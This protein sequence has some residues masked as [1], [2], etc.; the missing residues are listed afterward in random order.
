MDK[1]TTEETPSSFPKEVIVKKSRKKR[2][3]SGKGSSQDGG[4][5]GIKSA[6]IPAKVQKKLKKEAVKRMLRD[7]LKKEMKPL[8]LGSI[9]MLCST[10]SNQ[11]T[12]CV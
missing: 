4:G 11:G 10:A 3:E 7:E 2:S 12:L 9:A 6:G 1:E 5:L 8:F